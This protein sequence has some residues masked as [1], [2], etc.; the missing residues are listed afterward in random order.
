MLGF[1]LF[2]VDGLGIYVADNLRA[3][4]FGGLRIGKGVDGTRKVDSRGIGL[5]CS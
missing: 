2:L 5:T 4:L 3:K 1:D